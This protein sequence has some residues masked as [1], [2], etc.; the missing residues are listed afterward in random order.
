MDYVWLEL[1]IVVIMKL[2]AFKRIL[3]G[4][5]SPPFAESVQ[6]AIVKRSWYKD[7]YVEREKHHKICWISGVPA[8]ATCH[9]ILTSYNENNECDDGLPFFELASIKLVKVVRISTH[10][11]RWSHADWS[12]E[13]CDGSGASTHLRRKA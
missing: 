7:R 12:H 8:L 10:L 4:T 9:S 13:C 11:G 3:P 1:S 6:E 5:N 2:R